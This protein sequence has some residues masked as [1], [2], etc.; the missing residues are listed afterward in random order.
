MNLPSESLTGP[1]IAQVKQELTGD[2]SL[3]GLHSSIHYP[4]N[5]MDEDKAPLPWPSAAHSRHATLA[6]SFAH[7]LAHFAP[8]PDLLP[9]T[10]RLGGTDD[11]NGLAPSDHT[12]SAELD[13]QLVATHHITNRV[14]HKIDTWLNPITAQLNKLTE[15]YQVLV[16]RMTPLPAPNTVIA[17]PI[18]MQ[19]VPVRA[20][21]TLP[22]EHTQN[23]DSSSIPVTWIPPALRTPAMHSQGVA[24]VV[25]VSNHN[26]VTDATSEVLEPTCLPNIADAAEFPSLEETCVAIPSRNMRNKAAK[27]RQWCSVPGA[28]GPI[29]TL[30]AMMVAPQV[31]DDNGHIPLKLSHICPMFASIVTQKAVHQHQQATRT[32]AQARA[33]QNHTSLGQ[34]GKAPSDTNLSITYATVIWHG[35]QADGD[36]EHALHV[37]VLTGMTLDSAVMT[38]WA[39]MEN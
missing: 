18:V 27:A 28:T 14:R 15:L 10:A 22:R 24:K 29:P 16:D 37:T 7:L 23:T 11:N 36:A 34:Q 6:P 8:T 33:V 38:T 32:G 30:Q 5:R 21:P 3:R 17:A 31:D 12:P 25:I 13:P 2:S 26:P 4:P 39:E 1:Q 19:A 35:G 20:V 9:F